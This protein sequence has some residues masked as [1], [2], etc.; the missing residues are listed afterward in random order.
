MLFAFCCPPLPRPC[1]PSPC[2][3]GA[4]GRVVPAVSRLSTPPALAPDPATGGGLRLRRRGEEQGRGGEV[5]AEGLAGRG[6][7]SPRATLAGCGPA[8]SERLSP[9]SSRPGRLSKSQ[10]VSASCLLAAHV[11]KLSPGLSCLQSLGGR[12]RAPVLRAVLPVCVPPAP[13][14]GP[15]GRCGNKRF[16]ESAVIVEKPVL[17]GSTETGVPLLWTQRLSRRRGARRGWAR[18]SAPGRLRCSWGRGVGRGACHAVQ[19]PAHLCVAMRSAFGCREPHAGLMVA[20]ATVPFV[21][22]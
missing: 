21:N 13:S 7:A 4:P 2:R 22:K 8:E 20:E 17:S 16:S 9:R 6:E 12:D 10:N 1:R 5:G 18:G 14:P 19:A 15:M 3:R 11:G